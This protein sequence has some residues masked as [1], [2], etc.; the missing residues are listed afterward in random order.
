MIAFLFLALISIAQSSDQ[1][2]RPWKLRD[3]TTDGC[4]VIAN[5]DSE[6]PKK[7]EHCCLSHDLA[8]WAGGSWTERNEAD[9]AFKHC[10][11]DVGEKTL[12]FF[13]YLGLRASGT[14]LLPTP[15]RWGYG[16]TG[17]R[18]YWSLT[19]EE[20]AEVTRRTP[21]TLSVKISN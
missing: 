12:A 20:K 15:F 13:G 14:A 16:W 10:L 8:Y 18:G 7:W 4:T 5:G 9:L 11:E 19:P 2:E 3:F 17:V 1:S 21:A 6:N